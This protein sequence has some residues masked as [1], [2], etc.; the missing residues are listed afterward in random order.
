MLLNQVPYNN[1]PSLLEQL[2]IIQFIKT[3]FVVIM[4][5]DGM[6]QNAHYKTE[7]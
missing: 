2:I 5:S 4:E 6:Q 7:P 1:A 3:F